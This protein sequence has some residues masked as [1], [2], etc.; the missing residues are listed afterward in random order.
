MK[1]NKDTAVCL[2]AML[3]DSSSFLF[4]KLLVPPQPD[5]CMSHAG[6]YAIGMPLQQAIWGT[7]ALEAQQHEVMLNDDRIPPLPWPRDGRDLATRFGMWLTNYL[8]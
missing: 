4:V 6:S 3:L 7:L 5:G 1:S 2:V 8:S